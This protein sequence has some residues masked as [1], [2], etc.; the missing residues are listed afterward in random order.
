MTLT[1]NETF[2]T[3][4]PGFTTTSGDPVSV[5]NDG[6]V[7]WVNGFMRDSDDS[8]GVTGLV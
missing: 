8:L 2:G 6:T 3:E 4:I 1:G 5:V 7:G